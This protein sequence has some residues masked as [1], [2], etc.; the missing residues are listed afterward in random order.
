[1]KVSIYQTVGSFLSTGLFK[2]NKLVGEGIVKMSWGITAAQRTFRKQF[3]LE[4]YFPTAKGQD[5]EFF[6][7]LELL[8]HSDGKRKANATYFHHGGNTGSS[9]GSYPIIP[10]AK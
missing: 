9:Q 10:A 6:A 8:G 7:E 3:F 1:M 4:F 2:D 5:G